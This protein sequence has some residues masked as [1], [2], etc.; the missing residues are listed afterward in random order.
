MKRPLLLIY[1]SLLALGFVSAAEPAAYLGVSLDPTALPKLLA[2]HLRLEP[3]QGL[4]IRNLHVGSPADRAGLQ[5]HDLIITLNQQPV[6]SFRR[7][8][9]QIMQSPVGQTVSLGILHQGEK[10]SL[11][12]ELE[13]RPGEYRPRY[14]LEPSSS[15]QSHPGRIYRMEPG[16]DQWIEIDPN[17]EIQ[18]PAPAHPF[19]DE[20][21]IFTYR[22]K[23][24]LSTVTIHGHP[25]KNTSRL[26]VSQDEAQYSTRIDEIDK[27]PPDI[28][29]QA[30]RGLNE[31]R[32]MANRRRQRQAWHQYT[33]II[34][35]V[36]NEHAPTDLDTAANKTL[37]RARQYLDQL[38][39]ATGHP[40]PLRD[41][42]R[43]Y[44]ERLEE[45]LKALRKRLEEVEVR[46]GIRPEGQAN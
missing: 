25:Q 20:I 42:D 10:R 44:I 28:Q 2:L 39:R 3:G 36:W 38:D 26:S 12:I 40:R 22:S 43:Q 46:S 11:D 13:D 29:T 32:E 27:L 4:R 7:F 21:Y 9:E 5:R 14:D 19:A 17:T 24:S 15:H 8:S 45:E 37:E 6:F 1:I 30:R 31:A 41:E 16:K 35:D 23:D 34:R 18:L 33:N